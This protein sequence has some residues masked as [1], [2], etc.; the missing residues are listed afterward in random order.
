MRRAE[1]VVRVFGYLFAGTSITKKVPRLYTT[2]WL[3]APDTCEVTASLFTLVQTITQLYNHRPDE[4]H[5][6][7]TPKFFMTAAEPEDIADLLA[8]ASAGVLR[9]ESSIAAAGLRA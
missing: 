7:T 9:I 1:F 5:A 2:D 8:G 6:D 3:T 4:H